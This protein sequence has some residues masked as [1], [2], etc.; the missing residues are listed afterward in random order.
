MIRNLNALVNAR[1]RAQVLSLLILLVTSTGIFLPIEV[2]L[3]RIWRFPDNRS[4]LGNQAIALGLAFGCGILALLSIGLTA[5]NVLLLKT[6]T[7]G[8]EFRLVRLLAFLIMKVFAI[9]ASIVKFR[10]PSRCPRA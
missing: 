1:N 7:F 5:S 6:L 9:A 4:Y 3:N 8:H 2:A 10:A